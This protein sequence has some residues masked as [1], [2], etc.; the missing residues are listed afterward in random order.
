MCCSSSTEEQESTI[1]AFISTNEAEFFFFPLFSLTFYLPLD[2]LG[3]ERVQRVLETRNRE[4]KKRDGRIDCQSHALDTIMC[5]HMA[6]Q[7]LL[8]IVTAD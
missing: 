5:L 2:A 4:T 1:A 8:P 3:V 6:H 7:L